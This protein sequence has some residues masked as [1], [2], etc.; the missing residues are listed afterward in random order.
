M[1]AP[2]LLLLTLAL[3]ARLAESNMMLYKMGLLSGNRGIGR[4]YSRQGNAPTNKMPRTWNQSYFANLL[5]RRAASPDDEEAAG[6]DGWGKKTELAA[7]SQAELQRLKWWKD[8]R[9]S[10]LISRWDHR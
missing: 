9:P 5:F 2:Y 1:R 10:M 6:D 8:K 4:G 7:L 3:S